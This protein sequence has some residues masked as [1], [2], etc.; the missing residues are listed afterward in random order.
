MKKLLFVFIWTSLFFSAQNKLPSDIKFNTT[1][2]EAEN[3]WVI[4]PI[5]E[6]N[7]KWTLYYVYFDDESGYNVELGDKITIINDMFLK[8]K[9]DAFKKASIKFR[10]QNLGEKVAVLSDE[11]MKELGL[12]KLPN[13][14]KLYRSNISEDERK[15]R[16]ARTLNEAGLTGISLATLEGLRNNNFKSPQFYFQLA[17]AYNG[18]NR[19]VDAEKILIEA[20]NNGIKDDFLINQMHY[21]LLHEKGKANQAADFLHGNLNDIKNKNLKSQCI[22]NQ[23]SKFYNINDF[24]KTQD[25]IKIYKKEIGNDNNKKIVEQYQEALST[26]S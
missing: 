11:R 22:I 21:A 8:D 20:F 18:Q 13:W 6:K 7:S 19:F 3:H 17:Y 5:G 25:W 9:P 12:E 1:I 4:F 15:F 2:A 23:I 16:K 10:I 24:S 26:K 14:L